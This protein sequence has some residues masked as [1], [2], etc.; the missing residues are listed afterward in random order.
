MNENKQPIFWYVVDIV[1][2]TKRG[3]NKVMTT[4]WKGMQCVSRAKTLQHL[5]KK[6]NLSYIKM[7]LSI[8]LKRSFLQRDI[9]SLKNFVISFQATQ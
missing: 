8:F 9:M 5:N 6:L 7:V 2:Q 1:W 3:K 4:R